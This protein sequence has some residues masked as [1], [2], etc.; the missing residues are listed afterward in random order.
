MRALLV[1]E[2][3]AL[4]GGEHSFL[5]ALPQLQSAG[6]QFT[7]ALPDDSD[8]AELLRK[9]DV[10][11]VTLS[12]H[13]EDGTKKPQA[14]IRSDL[15]RLIGTVNPKIVHANSLAASRILGPVTADTGTV[16]LG[17]IRDIIK[18]SRKAIADINGLDAI[19]SVSK[20][21]A[22]FHFANGLSTEKTRVIHNGVDL[23]VF[24]PAAPPGETATRN[25][26]LCIGQIGLRKGLDL[27]LQMLSSAFK[28]ADDAELW[29][30]GE[31]HSR[32]Q[33]SIDHELDLRKFANEN[34][35]PKSVKWLGR[36]IDIPDLMRI[37]KLLVH[38]ARQEPLGR[39][40]LEAAA[41]GLP[42]VTTNVGGTPEILDGL[43][44]LMFRPNQFCEAAGKAVELL[45]QRHEHMRVSKQ[46]RQIAELKFSSLR[47]GEE[48]ANYYHSVIRKSS[49]S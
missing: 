32:K 41:S 47:A 44:E 28:Q 34:F 9:R 20:A 21:T 48:L 23:E 33:E 46:L 10:D 15:H 18:L 22:E 2:F 43:D 24:K 17:Y 19:V 49:A 1:S 8:F 29:I 26:C 45:T 12:F 5:A 40:L 36:R 14:E 11:V 39:V 27:S 4:N 31:R 16:G 35:A 38:G 13:Y 25:V 37:A 6:F 30:V 3:G 7:A 42:I